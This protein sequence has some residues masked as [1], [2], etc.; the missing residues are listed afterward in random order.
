M[1]KYVRFIFFT[2]LVILT[3]VILVVLILFKNNIILLHPKNVCSVFLFLLII[4]TILYF[5]FFK[6]Y[7]I[8]VCSVAIFLCLGLGFIVFNTSKDYSYIYSSPNGESSLIIVKRNLFNGTPII[9]FYKSKFLFF[10]QSIPYSQ[11]YLN[12]VYGYDIQDNADIDVC[13]LNEHTVSVKINNGASNS[14]YE[15]TFDLN[16]KLLNK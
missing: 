16:S 14:I 3:L 6:K 1:K 4:Y 2:S 13:W 15:S 5:I 7:K 12:V 9:K 8:I 10:K 11:S